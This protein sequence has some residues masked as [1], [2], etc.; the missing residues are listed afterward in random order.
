MTKTKAP[1]SAPAPKPEAKKLVLKHQTEATSPSNRTRVKLGVGERVTMTVT[2]GP[3]KWTAT[4]GKLSTASGSTVTF[5]AGETAAKATVRVEVGSQAEEVEF[6]V[7][8]PSTVVQKEV[9]TQHYKN[10]LPNAGFFSEFFIGPDD[11]SFANISTSEA[12]VGAVASGSWATKNGKGHKPNP[13][14]VPLTKT[15]VAGKGTKGPVNDHCWSGFVP[16]ATGPDW[17]GQMSH[18]IPWSYHIGSTKG[19]IKTVEQ[20]VVTD[21]AGNTT[22]TKAGAKASY[23]LTDPTENI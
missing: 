10:G 16:G 18:Q 19:S 3:G 6:T 14:P 12:E 9:T 4:A 21:K 7:I 8:Q 23:S 5:I 15:V 20:L 2:P 1:P 22:I 11:V 13:D 17:T